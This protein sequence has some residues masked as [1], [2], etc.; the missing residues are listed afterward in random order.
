MLHFLNSNHDQPACRAQVWEGSLPT[1]LGITIGTFWRQH[2]LYYFHGFL[3][4]C[5][6]ICLKL[7]LCAQSALCGCE[8]PGLALALWIVIW[9]AQRSHW[10]LLLPF[11]FLFKR[12]CRHLWV[13]LLFLFI[14]LRHSK[15]LRYFWT[16]LFSS[17]L[18][19]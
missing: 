6:Y 2:E 19:D 17:R 15:W 1:P 5:C 14:D 11:V 9:N 7:G 16:L 4:L 18:T 13:L 12:D 3:S 8:V 10:S